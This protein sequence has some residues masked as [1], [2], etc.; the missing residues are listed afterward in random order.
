MHC[1]KLN[2]SNENLEKSQEEVD[3]LGYQ[4]L[5]YIAYEDTFKAG[6]E[7]LQKYKN[8]DPD[9]TYSHTNGNQY[10]YEDSN[11]NLVQYTNAPPGH[12]DLNPE[13]GDARLVP[14][15]PSLDKNPEYF[16]PD[17]VK[18]SRAPDVISENVEW[19]SQ[20]NRYDPQN[21]WIG[22][23]RASDTGD[24]RYTYADRDIR[25][26][27]NLEVSRMNTLLDA[28]LPYFRQYVSDLFNSEYIKDQATALALAL[29]DQGRLRVIDICTL[30]PEDVNVEGNIITLGNRKI[31]GD[32]AVQV[33]LSVLKNNGNPGEPL[34]SIYK[35]QSDGNAGDRI[36]L[37]P[38]YLSKVLENLGISLMSFQTYHGTFTFAR[39]V[40]RL[41][42][43]FGVSWEQAEQQAMLAVA[44]EWGHDFTHED[45][46]VFVLDLIKSLLIDPVVYDVLKQN[47]E[48]LGISGQAEAPPVSILIPSVSMDLVS[49]TKEEED[50]STWLHSYPIHEY[51][52]FDE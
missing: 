23:W 39:E 3:D 32:Y 28:R 10:W 35:L 12:A 7:F 51:A 30:A 6:T 47:V 38:N 42:L 36:R 45:D 1:I 34:F 5:L 14:G 43:G 24:Y 9:H 17:G 25:G 37:G 15:Q 40:A 29:L 52:K 22:R 48:L 26:V 49:R 27:P 11:Q 18:L 13:V 50:F 21:L 46:P 41:V 44:L 33:A 4:A 16:S 20:Y 19:N 8:I 2:S 31:Y